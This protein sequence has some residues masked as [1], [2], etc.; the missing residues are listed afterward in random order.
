MKRLSRLQNDLLLFQQA[1]L[2]TALQYQVHGDNVDSD[3]SIQIPSSEDHHLIGIKGT[4]FSNE[5]SRHGDHKIYHPLEGRS[6][7]TSS[8]NPAPFKSICETSETAAVEQVQREL[9]QDAVKNL[10]VLASHETGRSTLKYIESMLLSEEF[11]NDVRY[12]GSDFLTEYFKQFPLVLQKKGLN[13]GASEASKRGMFMNEHL[14]VKRL[15]GKESDLIEDPAFLTTVTRN[16]LGHSNEK[17]LETILKKFDIDSKLPDNHSASRKTSGVPKETKLSQIRDAVNHYKVHGISQKK[18]TRSL[19]GGIYGVIEVDRTDFEEQTGPSD[20]GL[21]YKLPWES[22]SG[23]EFFNSHENTTEDDGTKAKFIVMQNVHTDSLF[24]NPIEKSMY[25][26]EDFLPDLD[27][28]FKAVVTKDAIKSDVE[29]I[30]FGEIVNAY[31]ETSDIPLEGDASIGRTEQQKRSKTISYDLK[32]RPS[33]SP[34]EHLDIAFMRFKRRSEADK[35]R[36]MDARMD[37]SFIN[38]IY[39]FSNFGTKSPQVISNLPLREQL[40]YDLQF[41]EIMNL[42]DYSAAVFVDE[43]TVAE[44]IVEAFYKEILAKHEQI[45]NDFEESEKY[46][47]LIENLLETPMDISVQVIFEA[48]AKRKHVLLVGARSP[49]NERHDDGLIDFSMQKFAS[50]GIIDY[51]NLHN[52]AGTDKFLSW[53][54]SE[55]SYSEKRLGEE[56]DMASPGDFKNLYRKFSSTT[57]H[58]CINLNYCNYLF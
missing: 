16:I 43:P 26:L 32:F 49:K 4:T 27:A 9:L 3:I 39:E 30:S 36:R 12:R 1:L 8:S 28:S 29:E 50:F 46:I 6:P 37:E 18:I 45:S 54:K 40:I 5:G 24:F 52:S 41:L 21:L 33:R 31:I 35:R 58:E 44:R 23:I 20:D 17:P 19:I 22:S 42:I 2:F 34:R 55:F 38:D 48:V 7:S 11:L 47:Q 15:T 51:L 56:F 25:D 14:V 53:V 13:A 57:T 10:F